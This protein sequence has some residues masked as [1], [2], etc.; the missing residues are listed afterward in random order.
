MIVDVQE[1]EVVIVGGG[2]RCRDLLTLFEEYEPRNLKLKILGVADPNPEAPGAKH[3]RLK[4][5]FVTKDFHELL[6][7]FPEIDLIIELTGKDEV[8]EEIFRLKAPKTKVLDHV[9]ATLFAEIITLFREKS[10]YERRLVEA[11]TRAL[12][13]ELICHLAHRIRNPLTV[14]GGLAK[15]M[16]KIK[17][18]PK[19][20]QEYARVIGEE[21]KRLEEVMEELTEVTEPL[22][23]RFHP[24]D[25]NALARKVALTFKKDLP[26]G[27][28]FEWRLEPDIPPLYADANLLEKALLE[29]L[30]NARESL[31]GRSGQIILETRL[32]YDSTALV[33]IDNGPGMDEE[34]LKKATLPFFTTKPKASGLGLYLVKKVA[35]AH[36]GR[37]YLYSKPGEGTIAALELP[38][39]V[40]KPIPPV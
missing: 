25:L 36:G 7:R 2:R 21:V 24:V 33:V 28:K 35:R 14:I 15:R 38:M 18:L 31:A 17:G 20:A 30:K 4:G 8:L 23:P 32:C 16:T 29:L 3:A 5:L 27:I 34:T 26:Q 6:E 40:K 10:L 11:E 1:I 12:T 9:G 22:S 19:E 13:M 39:R 37:L